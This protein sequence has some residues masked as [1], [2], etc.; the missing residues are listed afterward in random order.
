MPGLYDFIGLVSAPASTLPTGAPADDRPQGGLMEWWYFNGHFDGGAGIGPCSFELTFVRLDGPVVDPLHYAYF[1]FI[2]EGGEYL[3]GERLGGRVVRDAPGGFELVF[4][5]NRDQPGPWRLAADLS[6][7]QPRHVIEA[8]FRTRAGRQRAVRLQLASTKPAVLHGGGD[9]LPM[10]SGEMRLYSRTRLDVVG[11]VKFDRLHRTVEGMGWMDHQWGVADFVTARWRYVSIQLNDGRDLVAWEVTRAG[12]PNA[13]PM[14]FAALVE[15]SGVARVLPDV[16]ILPELVHPAHGYALVHV[17]RSVSENIEWEVA[18]VL[19]D[20]RRV[21][22]DGA[23][24]PFLTL[25][26]AACVVK[27]GGTV[28]GRGFTEVGGAS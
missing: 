19:A 15:A 11:G 20:Q 16:E 27:S 3:A 12:D 10:G 5:A 28:I 25:W 26:E 6:G 22:T 7:S 24:V 8:A 17:V 14:T 2:Q 23:A 9:W 4:P 13:R 18:S 1:A 21:P